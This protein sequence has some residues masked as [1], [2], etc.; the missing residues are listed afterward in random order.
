VLAC[1]E[2]YLAGMRY[3]LAVMQTHDSVFSIPTRP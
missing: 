1:I 2:S 3:P